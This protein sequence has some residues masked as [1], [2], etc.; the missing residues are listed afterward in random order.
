MK[1]IS[2]I[3]MGTPEFCVPILE[4]LINDSTNLKYGWKYDAGDTHTIK[5]NFLSNAD[6]TTSENPENN[7]IAAFNGTKLD[8][9]DVQIRCKVVSTANM[10]KKITNI[11]DITGCKDSEGNVI[12]NPSTGERDSTVKNVT[13]P[14]DLSS[15]RDQEINRQDPTDPDY[16]PGQEDDDDFEKLI[17]KE[18]D[19]SL[20]KFITAVNDTEI[21]NREP[22]VDVSPLKGTSTTAKYT[23]KISPEKNPVVVENSDIVTYTIRVYNEGSVSGYAKEVKDDIPEGLEFLPENETNKEYRWVMLDENGEE[24]TEVSKAKTIATDYLSKEQEKTAGTNLI[25]AFDPETM[26]TLD[27]KDVKVA[28]KV[29]ATKQSDGLIVNTA[30]ISKASDEDIDSTPGNNVPGEDDID[31]APVIIS[32]ATGNVPTYVTLSAISIGILAAGVILIKKFV[33]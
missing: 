7:K 22:Q 8:Y 23:Y 5:T 13:I 31:D 3:F 12:K 25:K 32:T 19:L 6:G 4:Y 30:E 9:R 28:F 18:F 15:Y 27:Y 2:V 17:L 33:I 20:K 26:D 14:A 29:V 21:T 16:I 10:P 1:N 11:A 24:T